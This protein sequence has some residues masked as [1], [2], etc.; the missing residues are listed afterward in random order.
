MLLA[1]GPRSQGLKD[2]TISHR[3]SCWYQLDKYR[4]D[5]LECAH[6]YEHADADFLVGSDRPGVPNHEKMALGDLDASNRSTQASGRS[7]TYDTCGSTGIFHAGVDLGVYHVRRIG[8]V[9]CSMAAI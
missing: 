5:G 3:A 2:S 6:D 8:C 1:M 7:R 4:P 9:D